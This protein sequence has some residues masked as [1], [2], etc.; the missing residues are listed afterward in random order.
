MDMLWLVQKIMRANSEVRILESGIRNKKI[1][2]FW[3]AI[4]VTVVNT[5]LM[6]KSHQIAY[7]FGPSTTHVDYCGVRKDQTKFL[8][9]KKVF[10][11]NECII[12]HKPLV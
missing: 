8:I 12:Q 11:G 10:S 4:I 3:A 2:E 9:D 6:R 7:D 1:L 5:I